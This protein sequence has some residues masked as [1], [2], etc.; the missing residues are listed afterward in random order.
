MAHRLGLLVQK[1]EAE[2]SKE[3]III[4]HSQLY[5]NKKT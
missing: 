5:Q 1:E 4:F 2:D 3:N